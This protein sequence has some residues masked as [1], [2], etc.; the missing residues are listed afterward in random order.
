[1]ATRNVVLTDPQSRFIDD[2]VASGRYQN[3]S[4]AL[5][6]G[7]RLLEREEIELQDMRARLMRGVEQARNGDLAEG[8]GEEVLRRA[9]DL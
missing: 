3:A 7:L 2:L 5:R 1:M 4:E 9:F 6:A 8:T